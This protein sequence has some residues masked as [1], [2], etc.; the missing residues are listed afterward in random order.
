MLFVVSSCLALL[1]H[2]KSLLPGNRAPAEHQP[3]LSPP[4]KECKCLG[5][6]K[7][8]AIHKENCGVG[9]SGAQW[10]W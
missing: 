3:N 1:Q 9:C 5:K 7:R 8:E 4:R 6:A 2:T 10:L